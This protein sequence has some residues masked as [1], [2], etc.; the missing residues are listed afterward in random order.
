[1]TDSP[2]PL[3]PYDAVMSDAWAES[4]RPSPLLLPEVMLLKAVLEDAI[5]T[6]LSPN[7]KACVESRK[8]IEASDDD[9]FAFD[10]ICEVLGIQPG[11][12]RKKIMARAEWQVE[13]KWPK[14][15]ARV[16][17]GRPKAA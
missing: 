15:E 14:W 16:R 5:N 8:W 10:T 3:S 13:P 4:H 12:L 11:S 7:H 1:M 2:T 6:A 9:L 17:I